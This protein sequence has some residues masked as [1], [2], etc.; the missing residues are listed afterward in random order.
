MALEERKLVVPQHS[1]FFIVIY[2]FSVWGTSLLLWW[3]NCVSRTDKLKAHTEQAV[4]YYAT[5]VRSV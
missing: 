4:S 5:Q 2:N 3:D 1:Y